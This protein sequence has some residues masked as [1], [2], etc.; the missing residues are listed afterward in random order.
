MEN[1]QFEQRRAKLEELR[2]SGINPFANDFKPTHLAT[3]LIPKYGELSEEEIKGIAD[4]F[5]L[6]GRVMSIRDFGKS[7]FFHISDRSG[8]IQGYI[9]KDVVGDDEHK[10]FK[11]FVDLGDFIGIK[12]NLFKTRTGEL[13]LNVTEYKFLTKSLH[14][15]PEKW[16]GLKDVEIRYRQRYLD[17]IS[18]PDIKEIFLTR[19]K[20]INLIRRFLEERDFVEVETPI[21]HPIA[22]GAAA[23]PFETHHNALDMDFV[24]RIAPELYLKRLVVGGIERVYEIGRT[25][26]NEGVSTQHN[27]EFTMMELYQA[28][29]TYEDLMDLT[30]EL[31]CHISHEIKNTLQFEYVD[32][33]IDMTRPWKRM[34]ISESLRQELGDKILSDDKE[35]FKKADSL[36]IDHKGIRG[37]AITEIFESIFE[38]KLTN[39]TFVYGF[40]LDVSPL[41]RKNEENP[42]ITDRFE[43]Y[44]SG[45]EIANAFSELNDP[46]DQKERFEKQIELKNK[47]EEEVHEM[48]QDYITALEHGMP[49]TAGEGIGIDRLV[50]LFTNSPSI[51]EVIFFPHLRP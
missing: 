31:I 3:D 37:K 36:G 25:F 32:V 10:A 13:T 38:D 45:R 44:I 12:G 9:K 35:L 8:K 21:L 48:D 50:M 24:L 39:P 15:L 42:E 28:Y 16:H 2:D 18:N 5:S 51:R 26:R 19:S 7:L 30:E 47:G 49:P 17:L 33:Q 40:P 43:L 11:K 41:A 22:G 46:V 4:E 29:A 23:R 1:E 20:I 6:A 27:P 34:D 14:P